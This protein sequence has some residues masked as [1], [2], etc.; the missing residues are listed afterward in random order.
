MISR[1]TLLV[2]TAAGL[3]TPLDALGRGFG[4][5]TAPSV[6]ILHTNDLHGRFDVPIPETGAP[7]A[8]PRGFAYLAREMR[9]MRAERPDALVL[10]AGDI[11]HG[12][13]MEQRVGPAPILRA[14]NALGYHAA[15]AGNH[16]FDFGPENLRRAARLAAF[17]ILSANVRT[18][19]GDPWGPLVPHRI[20]TRG[21]T[22]IGLFGLTTTATPSIQWPRTIEGILFEDPI[23]HARRCVAE[24]RPK[25]DLVVCLSHLGYK[26]DQKLAAEVPGI[27]LIVGGHSHTRLERPTVV[28]GIPIVQTGA[29]GAAFGRLDLTRDGKGWRTEYRLIDADATGGKDARVDAVYAPDARRLDADLD[30]RIGTLAAPITDAELTKRPTGSGRFLAEAVR[31]ASGTDVGL[32]S[33]TQYGGTLPAGPVT[34]RDVY[35][36]TPAYTRQHVVKAEVPAELLRAALARA[37]AE[38]AWTVHAT[39]IPAKPRVTLAAAAHV[40]QDLVYPKPETTVLADDPLG[41]TVRDAILTAIAAARSPK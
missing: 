37:N 27:D 21:R 22:R 26:P 7:G 10:D 34:R 14:M 25:V 17:P 3:F 9:R 36:R 13:P 40:I 38:G 35:A 11:V 4:P 41:P 31:D 18:P 32:Y 19:E 1:R 16:E 39:E 23:P 30:A 5:E 12:T 15:T 8:G 2:S 33:A 20:L 24:L 29:L 28:E 6:T